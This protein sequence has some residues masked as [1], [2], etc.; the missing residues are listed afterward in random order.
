[1]KG[2]DKIVEIS[3]VCGTQFA[4]KSSGLGLFIGAPS[5]SNLPNISFCGPI[6]ASH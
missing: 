2:L 1:M 6:P 5:G 3:K 4:R